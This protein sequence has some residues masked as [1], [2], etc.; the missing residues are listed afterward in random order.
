MNTGDADLL[1]TSVEHM[2]G[3]SAPPIDRA[4]AK[5]KLA[6]VLQRKER[7]FADRMIDLVDDL[8]ELGI[9]LEKKFTFGALK[10]LMILFGENYVDPP[11]FAAILEDEIRHL[12]MTKTPLLA[13]DGIRSLIGSTPPR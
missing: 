7:G 5:T 11:A 9:R 13:L 12:L 4:R 10:G 2:T 1:L 3:P 8:S 6:D